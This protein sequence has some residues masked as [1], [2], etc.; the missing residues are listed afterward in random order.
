MSEH[1]DDKW[2]LTRERG[3][4]VSHV[5]AEARAPY[6]ELGA[7]LRNLPA[8]A[9]S[10]DW[11]ARVL[12]ALDA[13][14]AKRVWPKST[15]RGPA[16]KVAPT[17]AAKAGY[18]A[19]EADDTADESV[20][21]PP[22]TQT[23]PKLSAAWWRRWLVP[24]IAVAAA[25]AIAIYLAMPRGSDEPSQAG[26]QLGAPPRTNEHPPQQPA[27]A[28]VALKTEL[29]DGANKVRSIR[30]SGDAANLNDT[31][32]AR[33]E[34]IGPAELRLYGDTNELLI[35]CG[36]R[37]RPAGCTV[38]QDGERRRFVLETVLGARGQVRLVT[39]IGAQI[40]ASTEDRK[41]D[42]DAAV[43]AKVTYKEELSFEV[44]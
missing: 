6:E 1:R 36:E 37:T 20:T 12:A 4:D 28:V 16:A 24:A 21:T 26:N 43:D 9:P 30:S 7:M 19:T 2:L 3:E 27:P 35:A 11:K 23:L 44:R 32:V 25:A 39:F 13:E 42:L 5:P 34:T 33:V 10:K 22:K 38:T 15:D 17:L 8:I 40:P 18:A 14:E 31:F 29:R 41:R